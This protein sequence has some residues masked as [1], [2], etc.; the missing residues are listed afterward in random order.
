MRL[1]LMRHGEAE[2][3]L[4]YDSERA[5]TAR[6]HANNLSVA[7]QWRTRIPHIPIAYCS[8]YL[9]AQQ[10]AADLLSII[11]ELEFNNGDWL[12][13]SAAV[14]SVFHQ[15]SAASAS[16]KQVAAVAGASKSSDVKKNASQDILLVGHNPL[17]S[18]VWN[19]LLNGNGHHRFGLSTSH[20]VSIDAAVLASACGSFEYTISP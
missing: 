17:L 7:R 14:A 19:D 11:P 6:G 13:P 8:P 1:Y 3:G 4:D 12:V 5:L 15:L 2:P 9:R 20:L 10:T 16:E 18:Q